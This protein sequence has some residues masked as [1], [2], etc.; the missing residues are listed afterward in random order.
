MEF[1]RRQRS[2]KL[3]LI[4]VIHRDIKPQN[5][6]IT[7]RGQV[8]MLDFG[9][10]KQLQNGRKIDSEARTETR[11]TEQGQTVGTVGYMSPEQLKGHDI[12]ARSDLFSLGVTLYECATGKPAFTGNSAA[13][14][15]S[16]TRLTRAG[17]PCLAA[18][19]TLTRCRLTQSLSTTCYPPRFNR[20]PS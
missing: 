4:G 11:L 19:S 18:C 2:P 20:P 9:L 12:D 14:E 17:T 6:I 7:P 8:K 5:L 3:I 15:L 16:A 1:R 13:H 10:A